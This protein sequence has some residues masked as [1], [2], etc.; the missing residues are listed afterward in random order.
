MKMLALA[1]A[2]FSVTVTANA[3]STHD[4]NVTQRIQTL[5]DRAAL[6]NLVDTFSVLADLKDVQRQALLFTEDAEVDSYSGGQ[7]VS[8]LTGRKQ[9]A[10]TFGA[11]LAKFETVYHINGQQTVELHGDKATGVSYC[12]V[13][14]IGMED[15]K[16][17]KNTAGVTYKDEYVRRGNEWLIAKRLSHFTW[18]DREE[19]AQPAR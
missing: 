5:E 13:V 17:I 16:K 11:Y 15:G 4:G 9:I 10:D 18:R 2:L 12:F 14:L 1:I 19:M 8:S 7:M 6:K 3:Q